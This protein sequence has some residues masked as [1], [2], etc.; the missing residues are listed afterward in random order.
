MKKWIRVAIPVVAVLVLV[1]WYAFRPERLVVNRSVNEAFP[2][3]QGGSSP[4][5]LVS[6]Q[7]Y[8]AF[9]IQRQGPQPFTRWETAGAF[10]A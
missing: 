5:S 8:I 7:F 4:Q 1:A 2:S 6:G 9:C 3:G 10:F